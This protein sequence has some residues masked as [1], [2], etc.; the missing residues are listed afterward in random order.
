MMI[1]T[2][3]VPIASTNKIRDRTKWRNYKRNVKLEN[4]GGPLDDQS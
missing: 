4:V 1:A 2:I 3:I